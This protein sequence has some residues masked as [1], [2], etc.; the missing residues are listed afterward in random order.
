MGEIFYVYKITNLINGKIYIGKTNDIKRRWKEHLKSSKLSQY[1]I[2]RAIRKYGSSN[3]LI[4][5][6]E[7]FE[8][9]NEALLAESKFISQYNSNLK[10]IGYNLTL[11]GEGISGY[12]FSE[13]SRNKISEALKGKNVGH[14]F[15]GITPEERK[16]RSEMYK[17]EGSPNSKLTEQKVKEIKKLL[18]DGL[19]TRK[20][21]KLFSVGKTIISDIKKGRC[22][23]HIIFQLT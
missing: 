17:G 1:P 13:E 5:K 20:I 7:E 15:Y 21:A 10:E 22:W 4:E 14:P 18:A 6:L 12:V 8:T 3:F 9:E 11:G 16:R 23:S 19:S 2:Y